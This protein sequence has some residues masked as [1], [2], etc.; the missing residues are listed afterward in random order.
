MLTHVPDSKIL[1]VDDT[2]GN[3]LSMGALF[4]QFN[5][6]FSLAQ[7]GADAIRLVKSRLQFREPM[8]DIIYMDF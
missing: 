4:E 2:L 8:F 6:K 5:L 3:L 1:I 7:T